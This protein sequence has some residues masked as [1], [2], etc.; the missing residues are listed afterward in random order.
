MSYKLIYKIPFKSLN[1]TSYVVEIE[2]KDYTGEATELIGGESPFSLKI[3]DEDF[4][5]VPTRFSTA[6]IKIVGDDRLKSLFATSYQEFRVTFKKDNAVKWIGFI[7]PEIYTQE[8]SSTISELE[9]ECV[10]P[11]MVLDNIKYKQ[12]IGDKLYERQFVSFLTILRLCIEKLNVSYNNIII[13][14]VYGKSLTDFNAGKFILDELM[15]SEQNFFDEDDEPMSCK[16]VIEEICKFM[17][18]TCNDW[19]GSLV[20]S[21]VDHNGEYFVFNNA[22]NKIGT[23]TS[24]SLNVQDIGFMG[25]EHSLDIVPGY[26]KVT[27]KNSNYGLN[28]ILDF[29]PDYDSFG[30]IGVR[31]NQ[32]D[33]NRSK[34]RIYTSTG[35]DARQYKN[36]LN[37]VKLED[38][39]GIPDVA[40][41]NVTG[42][43]PFDYCNYKVDKNGNPDITDYSYTESLRIRY[44]SGDGTRIGGDTLILRVTTPAIALP[45]GC[46]SVL[47]SAKYS[48]NAPMHTFKSD[49]Y[50][51]NLQLGFKLYVGSHDFTNE[52]EIPGSFL[53]CSYLDFEKYDKSKEF[54]EIKND[55]TLDMPY[56]GAKG[57]IIKLDQQNEIIAGSIRFELLAECY[58]YFKDKQGVFIKDLNIKFTTI[59]GER[60][61]TKEDKVYENVV[62]DNFIN[63]LDEIELKI[64]S[65]VEGEG[66]SFS[67]VL[68]KG[69]LSNSYSDYVKDNLFSIIEN[70]N[71]RPEEALINRIIERYKTTK[72]K[73]TQILKYSENIN[74]ITVLTDNTQ[75]NKKFVITGGEIDFAFEEFKCNMIEL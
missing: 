33:E 37:R 47:A 56:D 23:T 68:F 62:N 63:E 39:V 3:E 31:N 57:K 21:D 24:N 64:N 60:E 18:W 32:E 14:H 52:H 16:E 44:Q 74:P 55:K 61:V 72:L 29:K 66:A 13:P 8:Y 50:E 36:G 20:F 2:K 1:N 34:S 27:I 41:L 73:L 58:P 53:K 26:N 25:S 6:T 40:W 35:L 30:L 5:Y 12:Y 43:I 54:N 48:N 10:S 45:K 7:K 75:Q 38:Y 15:I 28:N 65:Y 4:L 51:G 67:K 49:S 70:K 19:N 9:I 71:I 46:I 17:S 11:M 69:F 59:N 42:L 22:F